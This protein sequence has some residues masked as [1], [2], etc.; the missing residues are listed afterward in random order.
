MRLFLTSIS[1]LILTVAFTQDVNFGV[2]FGINPFNKFKFVNSSDLYQPLN[3]YATYQAQDKGSGLIFNENKFF[4][5]VHFGASLRISRK[6]IGLHIEPQM[7]Y[8][9]IQ[10]TFEA[11]Y[12]DH[13]RILSRR[14][15]RL[16]IYATYH[17]FNNPLALHLNVGLIL[18]SMQVYDYQRP[19]ITYYT[20]LEEPYTDPD[21]YGERHFYDVFY[22][23]NQFNTNYMVGLGK[24]FNQLDY[25][26]R[27]VSGVNANSVRG[28]RWQIE[29]HINFF[30]LSKNEIISKNYLYEE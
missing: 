18:Q 9:Y 24:R 7:L 20:A 14:G 25:N 26:L 30:F 19:N 5:T 3:S 11:P 8:E 2:N 10:F 16:P 28:K 6:K 17:L 4:N 1:V 23:N 27:Y 12:P 15:F 13:S 22:N 29:L 21:N